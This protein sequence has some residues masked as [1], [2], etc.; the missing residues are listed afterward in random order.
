MECIESQTCKNFN[1]P[2]FVPIFLAS[3]NKLTTNKKNNVNIVKKNIEH[4]ELYST[5]KLETNS[6]HDLTFIDIWGST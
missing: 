5:L 4:R 1:M 3:I 2:M 6:T